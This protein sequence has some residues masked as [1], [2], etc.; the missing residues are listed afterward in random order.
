M[1]G[2]IAKQTTA[3]HQ[4]NP[5]P[6]PSFECLCTALGVCFALSLERLK[7][8]G[9]NSPASFDLHLLAALRLFRSVV[10]A[11][12]PPPSPSPTITARAQ[13]TLPSATSLGKDGLKSG[14]GAATAAAESVDPER[15]ADFSDVELER[16][17]ARRRHRGAEEARTG[18]TGGVNSGGVCAPTGGVCVPCFEIA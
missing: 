9:Q 14:I 12:R 15:L 8:I 13:Q 5:P 2:S 7:S 4:M 16:E 10:V 1:R 11:F 18:E 3:M 6:P 17:L